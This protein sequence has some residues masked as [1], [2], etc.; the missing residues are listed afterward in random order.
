MEWSHAVLQSDFILLKTNYVLLVFSS[1]CLK[2][3]TTIDIYQLP[4]RSALMVK[5]IASGCMQLAYELG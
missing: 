3:S 5:H 1:V 2:G 4:K